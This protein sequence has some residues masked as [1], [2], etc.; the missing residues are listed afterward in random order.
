[1]KERKDILGIELPKEAE[2]VCPGQFSPEDQLK[3]LGITLEEPIGSYKCDFSCLGRSGVCE[4][5][6][7]I[8]NCVLGGLCYFWRKN[9]PPETTFPFLVSGF[10]EGGLVGFRKTT[11]RHNLDA[12]WRHIVINFILWKWIFLFYDK[13]NEP[14]TTSFARFLSRQKEGS[15]LLNLH[16]LAYRLQKGSVKINLGEQQPWHKEEQVLLLTIDKNFVFGIES[17]EVKK[18]REE[19][20][21]HSHN[22][23]SFLMAMRNFKFRVKEDQLTK[24]SLNWFFLMDTDSQQSWNCNTFIEIRRIPNKLLPYERNHPLG[25]ALRYFRS[26]MTTQA[27]HLTTL[28]FHASKGFLEGGPQEKFSFECL[29]KVY[30]LEELV[31]EGRTFWSSWQSSLGVHIGKVLLGLIH[32]AP[33]RKQLPIDP[34]TW[35]KLLEPHKKTFWN[36]LFFLKTNGEKGKA[37]ELISHQLEF[38]ERQGYVSDGK[39][40]KRPDLPA[41]SYCGLK[42]GLK[43]L[44][45][46]VFA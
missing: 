39:I 5:K 14:Q 22:I 7:F 46:A 26:H 25:P 13:E 12:I 29:N 40:Q 43:K 4:N 34:A 17:G 36:F 19:Q 16:H 44:A 15:Q 42:D 21:L 31:R 9:C 38:L 41:E 2:W 3:I 45:E 18:T 20:Q 28:C 27:V 11:W 35:F 32:Y 23:V 33:R 24:H 6:W 8:K 30:Q 37:L 10:K 1:M